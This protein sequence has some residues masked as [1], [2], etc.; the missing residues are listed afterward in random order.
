MW[1]YYS[2][3]VQSSWESVYYLQYHVQCGW[4]LRD[5]LLRGPGH[6]GAGGHLSRTDDRPPRLPPAAQVSVLDRLADGPGNLGIEPHRRLAPPDQNSYWATGIRVA[7]LGHLPGVGPRLSEL[8]VGGPQFGTLTLTRFLTLHVGICTV[9]LLGL[10]LLHAHLAARCGME[11]RESRS[12]SGKGADQLPSPSGRGAGDEGTPPQDQPIACNPQRQGVRACRG[13]G[14]RSP[15]GRDRPGATWRLAA[16]CWASSW[17]CRRATAFPV[18]GPASSSAPGQ[19]RGG[20][21][22][23]T[24]RVVAPRSLPAP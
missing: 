13:R 11:S 6:A 1:M 7:Y 20:S 15:T 18:R 21:A 24:T 17:R 10:L 2:A 9:A 8:A 16:S 3:G 5:S 22:H 4:L 12:L 23:G 19:S 14:R